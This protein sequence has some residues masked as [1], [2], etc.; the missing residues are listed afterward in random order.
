MAKKKTKSR[1]ATKQEL[2]DKINKTYG[3]GTVLTGTTRPCIDVAAISTGAVPLDVAT[4]VGGIPRGRII[5]VYGPESGGKTTLSL[6]TIAQCQKNGG[7]VA[8]V[9]AEHALDAQWAKAI[10]VNVDDLIITQPSSGEE[11]LAICEE[12]ITSGQI[13]LIVVDS[14]AA[15][16]PQSELDG[17]IGQA[18]V[19][20]QA[21]MM[22]QC[23][24]KFVS[25]C[26]K[27]ECSVIFIN[28]IREKI[29]M[30]FGNPETTPGGRALKFYA[31]MRM[32]IRRIGPVK[33]GETHVGNAIKVK[34]VKNKVAPPFT[35]AKFNL[36]FGKRG[37]PSGIDYVASLLSVAESNGVINKSGSWYSYNSEKLG[38]GFNNS[39]AFVKENP[40]LLNNIESKVMESVSGSTSISESAEPDDED[41][42]GFEEET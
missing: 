18:S 39:V 35:E 42:D 38:L 9:D 7:S 2:L 40:E 23:M 27:T 30:M 24:R 12:F 17:E 21:R 28:Q 20:A 4:G 1:C 3:D 22:S 19:G 5:E 41:D 26:S 37:Y 6:S 15:L 32:E 11:A 10:G 33:D 14:V 36:Y 29:G 25:I 13:D 31:S 16:V 8:F 34:V